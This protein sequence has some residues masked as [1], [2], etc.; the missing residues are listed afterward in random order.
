MFFS[1]KRAQM[2]WMACWQNR[3]LIVMLWEW[4]KKKLFVE[5]A[6]F[7]I[8]FL[9]IRCT[10]LIL[11]MFLCTFFLINEILCYWFY[12]KKKKR[13]SHNHCHYIVPVGG[14]SLKFICAY[15]HCQM[16]DVKLHIKHCRMMNGWSLNV[17][18]A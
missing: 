4:H 17:K 14:R 3:E 10:S 7:R 9:F 8:A 15:F 16:G 5:A 6:S 18:K 1:Y 2:R 11:V 13:G 12:K